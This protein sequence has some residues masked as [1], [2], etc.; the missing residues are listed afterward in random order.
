LE[1][2]INGFNSP[3]KF[4]SLLRRVRWA[5][6]VVGMGKM[7]NAYNFGWKSEGKRPLGKPRCRWVDN[8]RMDLR[9]IGWE[10]VDWMHLVQDGDQWRALVNRIM[11]LLI[12]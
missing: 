2:Y 7:R 5:G 1:I 11:N 4:S 3:I 6:H 10:D 9:E 8:I 12:P